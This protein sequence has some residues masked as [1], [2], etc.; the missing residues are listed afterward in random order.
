[1]KKLFFY[2]AVFLPSG[3][4]ASINPLDEDFLKNSLALKNELVA[5][6]QQIRKVQEEIEIRENKVKNLSKEI[7]EI[8]K[9]IRNLQANV[10]TTYDDLITGNL[11]G[12]VNQKLNEYF[13]YRHQVAENQRKLKSLKEER[14]VIKRDLAD[15]KRYDKELEAE[16]KLL[17]K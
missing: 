13:K 7:H 1:M 11:A 16:I 14:K 12:E 9:L 3:N 6:Q 10:I 5:K 15:S 8:K 4:F 17:I 2:I